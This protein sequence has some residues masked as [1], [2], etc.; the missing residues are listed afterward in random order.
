LLRTSDGRPDLQGIWNFSSVT[1]LERPAEF[2]GK[3]FVTGAEATAL[4]KLVQSAAAATE[5]VDACY[6]VGYN[7][8]EFFEDA[9]HGDGRRQKA[10][11]LPTSLIV[12]PPDGHLP[13]LTPLGQKRTAASIDAFMSQQN[14]GPES[15]SL[16]ERCLVGFNAGPPMIPGAYNNNMQIVQTHDHVV[17]LTEMIHNARSVPLDGRPHLPSSIHQW[18]GDPRGRWEGDTLVIETTNF[19]DQPLLSPAPPSSASTEKRVIER[20]TLVDRDTLRYEFTV[21]DP[22]IYTAPWTARL[23]MHRG[24]SL[25]E[26]GC[27]EAN[28]AL[29]NILSA[30]R[31][32]E[33]AAAKP[34][35][36][37]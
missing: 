19:N 32:R 11:R 17:V 10:V 8:D 6:K 30:S 18:S 27:H 33:R 3:A 25:Y 26:Y 34:A 4:Q 12:D 7:P 23:D 16:G 35:A 24:T 29:K 36:A 2:A 9:V 21:I 20:F 37:R 15:R 31:A 28:Y 1:T 5:A 14:D 22:P 13:P